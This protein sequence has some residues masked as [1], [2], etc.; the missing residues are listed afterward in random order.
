MKVS[1]SQSGFQ[2]D[3][4]HPLPGGGAGL[5]GAGERE[6]GAVTRLDADV[7]GAGV[8]WEG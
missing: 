8:T 5:G 4:G 7:V 3:L 1:P 2:E 6:G